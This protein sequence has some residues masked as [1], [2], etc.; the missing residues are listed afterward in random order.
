MEYLLDLLVSPLGFLKEKASHFYVKDNKTKHFIKKY[1]SN[2]HKKP[3][4]NTTAYFYSIYNKKK[5]YSIYIINTTVF[6]DILSDFSLQKHYSEYYS[7]PTIV[8]TMIF[9]SCG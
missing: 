8:H 6:T 7:I 4:V 2:V 3:T 9:F 5:Y 1:Y